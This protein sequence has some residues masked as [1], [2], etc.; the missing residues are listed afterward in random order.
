MSVS[1]KSFSSRFRGDCGW[2]QS[3]E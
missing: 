3:S 1:L 2:Q